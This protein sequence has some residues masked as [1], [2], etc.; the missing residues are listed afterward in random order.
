MELKKCDHNHLHNISTSDY[1]KRLSLQYDIQSN[2]CTT[3]TLGTQKLWPLLTGGRSSEV[4]LCYKQDKWDH[5]IVVVVDK[6]SLFTG[7][8]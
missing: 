4:P 3:S 5:K 8:R 7:G 2:L 6:W 1:I